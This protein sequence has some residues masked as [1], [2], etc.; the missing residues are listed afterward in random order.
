MTGA[1]A[2]LTLVLVPWAAGSLVTAAWSQTW[3]VITRGHFRI[4]AWSVAIL[5]VMGTFASFAATLDV[6]GGGSQ[7]LIA[8]LFAGACGVYLVAQY[9]QS[10]ATAAL[11]GYAAGG[12]GF[13]TLITTA[14]LLDGWPIVLSAI[15]VVLGAGLLGAV[16][17]GMLL[18]HWYLNQPGLKPW[19]LERLTTLGLVVAAGAAAIG[20]LSANRL[21]GAPTEGAALGLPGFGQNLG[22]AFFFIWLGLVAFTAAV[23]YMARRCVTIRSIQ[24]ATGLYY[25]AILTAGV[26]E[27]LVRYL[28]VNAV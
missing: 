18:G 14:G 7:R 16:T 12:V 20:A 9:S 13:V 22:P 5:A 6:P 2:V 3:G 26:A 10:D 24:S 4:V 17:N 23:V 28:M 19:A 25:V 21:I 1:G 8:V 15:G 27:F 11:I